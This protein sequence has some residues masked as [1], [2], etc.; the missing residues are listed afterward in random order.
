MKD[1]LSTD[2]FSPINLEHDILRGISETEMANRK[3][4]DIPIIAG[5]V[6]KGLPGKNIKDKHLQASSSIMFGVFSEYEPE[7]LLLQQAHRKVTEQQL[8]LDRLLKAIARIN[9][10]EITLKRLIKPSPF[11]F[12]IMVERINRESFSN[13]TLEERV[14]KIQAQLENALDS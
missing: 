8:K 11:C 12:P 4:R 5:L 14:A 6:F 13:E 10:Q 1:A 7:N 2:L 3:F 9:E